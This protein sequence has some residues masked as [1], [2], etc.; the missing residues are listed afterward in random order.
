MTEV[1]LEMIQ[2]IARFKDFHSRGDFFK[3]FQQIL[4]F[5]HSSDAEMSLEDV[6]I[7]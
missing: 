1:A 2:L 6:E 7:K 3:F 4:D 5:K